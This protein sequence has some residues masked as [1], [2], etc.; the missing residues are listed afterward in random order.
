M[1]ETRMPEEARRGVGGIVGVVVVLVVVV[2]VAAVLLGFVSGGKFIDSAKS[3]LGINT[4]SS[5]WSRFDYPEGGFSV[6]LPDGERKTKVVDGEYQVYAFVGRDTL[7]QVS[8]KEVLSKDELDQLTQTTDPTNALK[9]IVV[10]RGDEEEK[11][12]KAAAVKI[13]KRQETAA[14]GVPAIYYE[15]RDPKP[16]VDGLRTD[17]TLK[18]RKILF[19]KSGILYTVDVTSVYPNPEQF[20]RV[21]GSVQITA[22]PGQNTGTTAAP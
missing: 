8:A 14:Y 15:T 18:E 13:D 2:V 7:I 6:E 21:A 19:I 20:D 5:G 4:P 3:R 9:R 22:P 11:N 16:T 10:A 12:M 1:Q 17:A